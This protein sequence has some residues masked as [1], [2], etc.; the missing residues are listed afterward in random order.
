M[1]PS[2]SRTHWFSAHVATV[3][4]R[5]ISARS[6]EPNSGN[7]QQQQTSGTGSEPLRT[8]RSHPPRLLLLLQSRQRCALL[9][10][11]REL[12]PRFCRAELT[13]T[14]MVLVLNGAEVVEGI[15]CF[16]SGFYR[17]WIGSSQSS[18]RRT[19]SELFSQND[20]KIASLLG[21]TDRT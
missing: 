20:Q 2:K 4:F 5:P 13:Q 11:A 3:T 18:G 17:R 1:F 16:S 7:E 19:Q 21:R 12:T 10:T 9:W 8:L 6:R 14:R 15:T